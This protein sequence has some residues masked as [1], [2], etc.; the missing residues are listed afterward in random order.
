M[1]L[2]TLGTE[3]VFWILKARAAFQISETRAQTKK[4][5]WSCDLLREHAQLRRLSRAVVAHEPDA[6]PSLHIPGDPAQNL[7]FSS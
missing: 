7:S 1:Y 3:E 6:L 5:P 4:G 2:E